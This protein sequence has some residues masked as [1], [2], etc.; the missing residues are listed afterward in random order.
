MVSGDAG[1]GR[2][3]EPLRILTGGSPRLLVIVA[4]FARHRSLRQLLEDLVTLIDN[5]TEYFRGHL[6][7]L[8]KTERRVYLAAIDL[9]QPSSTG[10]IAARA[11]MDVRSVSALLGRLVDRGAVLVDG[12]GRKR[13]YAAAERLYSI[14]Y[15]LRRERGDAAIVHHLIPFMTTFYSDDELAALA[16][17]EPGRVR[18]ENSAAPDLQLEVATALVIKGYRQIEI[19][20]AEEALRTS[21]ELERRCVYGRRARRIRIVAGKVDESARATRSR[22]TPGCPE[23][24]P[25]GVRQ[26]RRR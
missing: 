12:T 11:R 22:R 14:Y 2:E 13:R 24:F 25:V 10:E 5:H 23:C 7:V 8:A 17:S 3:I 6:D 16:V 20:R 4:E 21:D 19:G 26:V 18:L 15:K 9:W 1:K